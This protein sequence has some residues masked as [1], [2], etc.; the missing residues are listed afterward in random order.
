MIDVPHQPSDSDADIDSGPAWW[1]WK[2]PCHDEGIGPFLLF[3]CPHGHVGTL[4]HLHTG[5]G[6]VVGD[7]G[8][9]TPSVVC[10]R[11]HCPFHDFVRLL[12]W[13]PAPG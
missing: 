6:H 2:H 10:P 9:V 1:I 12:N 4:R 8:R 7:D 13:P 5:S 3:S 11:S